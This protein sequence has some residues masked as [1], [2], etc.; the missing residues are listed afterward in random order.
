M[1]TTKIKMVLARLVLSADPYVQTT[2]QQL[3][4]NSYTIQQK[5]P[6]LM[7][8][9]HVLFVVL[10]HRLYSNVQEPQKLI[11]L[12]MLKNVAYLE[13]EITIITQV[14]DVNPMHKVR[15]VKQLKKIL[16]MLVL[17]TV[18]PA[19]LGMLSVKDNV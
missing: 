4:A 2:R 14:R 3:L 10:L 19:G 13:E 5:M 16:I 18:K 1:D 12:Q 8:L 9:P 15:T 17:G 11:K 6:Q 7:K